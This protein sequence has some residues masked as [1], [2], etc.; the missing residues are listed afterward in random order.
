MINVSS[1]TLKIWWSE[2][3]HLPSHITDAHSLSLSFSPFTLDLLNNDLCARAR[4]WW[5]WRARVQGAHNIS[6]VEYSLNIH[7][8]IYAEIFNI[9]WFGFSF[10]NVHQS[11]M[12]MCVCLS[13]CMLQIGWNTK[14]V[15]TLFSHITWHVHELLRLQHSQCNTSIYHL[16]TTQTYASIE[17]LLLQISSSSFV[18]W[19]VLVAMHILNVLVF[20]DTLLAIS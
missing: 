16:A 2:C 12:Y 11:L 19:F 8:M 20:D 5:R 14:R 1:F 4:L 9:R 6:C 7:L 17:K 15:S 10:S 13:V 18:R 3:K